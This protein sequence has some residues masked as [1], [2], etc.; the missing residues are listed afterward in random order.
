MNIDDISSLV[1]CPEC[2]V[3]YDKDFTRKKVENIT[4]FKGYD[5]KHTCPVCN[6]NVVEID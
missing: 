4:V 6:N 3:V 1:T 5:Y 2:G